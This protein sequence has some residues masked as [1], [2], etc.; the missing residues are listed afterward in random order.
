MRC[1][2]VSSL[3]L[4]LAGFT[5]LFGLEFFLEWRGAGYPGLDDLSWA[6]LDFTKAH[7]DSVISIDKAAWQTELGLHGELF[8]QLS[9]RLPAQLLAIKADL[10]RKLAA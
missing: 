2:F 5:L 7:Y 6:G 8:Q 1:A 9:A 3:F 10:E 4:A